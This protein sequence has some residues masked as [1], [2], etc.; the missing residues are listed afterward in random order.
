M[1][2]NNYLFSRDLLSSIIMSAA[3]SAIIIVPIILLLIE[4]LGFN[5]TW[6]DINCGIPATSSLVDN[7]NLRAMA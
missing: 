6:F 5:L 3:F 4:A 1:K 2:K 7:L